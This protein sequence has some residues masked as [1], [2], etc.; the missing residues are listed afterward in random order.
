M[1]AVRAMFS[2]GKFLMAFVVLFL[3]VVV[4]FSVQKYSVLL[5]CGVRFFRLLC[6]GS[7]DIRLV[8]GN[9]SVHKSGTKLVFMG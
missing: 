6:I 2:A 9:A 1:C 5:L 4:A 3:V 8:Y 7:I